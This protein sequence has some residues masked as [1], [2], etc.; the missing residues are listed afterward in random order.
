MRQLKR[1]VGKKLRESQATVIVSGHIAGI[2]QIQ[3]LSAY[4]AQI[5]LDDG[6]TATVPA[7]RWMR[8]GMRVV[9]L[10]KGSEVL[11]T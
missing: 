2:Y 11:L 8:K 5:E 3:G 9:A 7:T 1:G 10:R 4:W 6:T